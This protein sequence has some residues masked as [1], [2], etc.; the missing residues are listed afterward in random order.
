MSRSDVLWLDEPE[1]HDYE[2]ASTYLTL[3]GARQAVEGIVQGLKRYDVVWFE[4]KDILRASTLPLLP[5][6][7]EHVAKDLKKVR[8]GKKLSPILLVCGDWDKGTPL[9][10]ADG[11]HRICASWYADENTEVPV[12]IF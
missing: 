12:R 10:V 3:L 2:A 11:Y 9:I 1:D 5:E 8:E 4:A 7:N 6:D